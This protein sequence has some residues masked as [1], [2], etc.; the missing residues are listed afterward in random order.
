MGIDNL[1]TKLF[2]M[3]LRHVCTIFCVVVSTLL[4]SGCSCNS[5]PESEDTHCI[6]LDLHTQENGQ[7]SFSYSFTAPPEAITLETTVLQYTGDSWLEIHEG[8][9][10]I[11]ESRKPIEQLVGTISVSLCGGTMDID[12]L[13]GGNTHYDVDE[14]QDISN[15]KVNI[16]L[17]EDTQEIFLEEEI[18][19]AIICYDCNGQGINCKP[20]EFRDF[21]GYDQFARVDV[22][23]VKF[24]EYGLSEQ[25]N[26]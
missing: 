4:I 17:L 9:I 1:N 20:S 23:T 10:S 3:R 7:A 21:E 19:V 22:V 8:G 13:C 18:P 24:S 15:L 11:G 16:E 2:I 12:I 26:H 5:L 14:I 6:V 25:V